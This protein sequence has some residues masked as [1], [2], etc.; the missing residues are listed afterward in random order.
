MKLPRFFVLL[1]LILL[2]CNSDSGSNSAELAEINIRLDRDPQRISPFFAPSSIGREVYQYIFL[3]VANY[4]PKTLELSPILITKIPEGR[5]EQVGEEQRIAF[6][7]EFRP[8]AKWSDGKPITARDYVFTLKAVNHP[9]CKITAWKPYFQYLKEIKQQDD[10]RKVTVYFDA[11][12]ML[13]QEVA[14]TPPIMPAHI[15][16]PTDFMSQT[17]IADIMSDNY[18][19]KD[20]IETK[21]IEAVNNSAVS[22]ENVVQSG[23]YTLS[24]FETN[25]YIQLVR[26]ENFW[27]DK[28]EG[29]PYLEN[30][31]GK[32]T[33]MIVPDE[34]TAVTMAKEGKIDLMKMRSSNSYQRLSKENDFAEDW[35]FHTPQLWA[36]YYMALN[37]KSRILKDAKVRRALAHLADIEDYIETLDG[38][39]GTRTSGHFHPVRSYYNKDI[40]LL[41]FDIE[42]AGN[43]LAEAGWVDNDGDGIREKIVNGQKTNLELDVLQSGNT[44]GKNVSLL[45]QASAEKAGVKINVITKKMSLMAKENL[46]DFNYDIAM[47]RVGADEA[48]DDPYPRWHSDNAVP[49]G[50]NILGYQ[51][52]AVDQLIEKL[53]KSR[54]QADR[55]LIYHEIQKEMYKDTPCV[56]LYC[57]LEKLLVSNKY[58]ALSTTKR[59]GYMANT[60]EL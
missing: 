34:L 32:I 8:E 14:L 52:K 17:S 30:N 9:K 43:L 5:I 22:K 53:R 15:F 41:E 48:S 44:L 56:F 7:L 3:T 46:R 57:P 16:D 10:P 1:T 59:P 35:T 51:N 12:Y 54:S 49:G 27:G 38:G 25:Q 6:D 19:D 13:A 40:P 21:L 20:S 4:H 11:D 29:V 2:A 28:I 18:T 24:S 47:L 39:M 36:Y 26:K 58:K 31:L 23:P 60:F 45:F 33:F 55:K 37:N 50:S 42:L